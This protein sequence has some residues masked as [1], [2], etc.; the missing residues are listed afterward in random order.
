MA[1]WIRRPGRSTSWPPVP[2][3]ITRGIYSV[4]V[5]LRKVRGWSGF[6][7][8]WT[9]RLAA[10]ICA[11]TMYGIGVNHGLRRRGRRITL[12]ARASTSRFPESVMATISARRLFSLSSAPPT[13]GQVTSGG[14]NA[15]TGKLGS[16]IAIR[17]CMKSAEEKRPVTT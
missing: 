14:A 6:R 9:A 13:E 15:N 7:P 17:P 3:S 1:G 2:T 4:S 5:T 11:G 16:T 8:F 12:V 10:K